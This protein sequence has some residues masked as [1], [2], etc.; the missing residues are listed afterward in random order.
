MWCFACKVSKYGIFVS[1]V[2]GHWLEENILIPSK[3]CNIS[4]RPFFQK[5]LFQF[6]SLSQ[7]P[8]PPVS[9]SRSC[10]NIIIPFLFANSRISFFTWLFMIL[11]VVAIPILN[12]D[13]FARSLAMGVLPKWALFPTGR[14]LTIRHECSRD[15]PSS[16]WKLTKLGL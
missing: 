12:L 13:L 5:T 9:T 2:C 11:I 14:R 16:T 15:S 6:S 10:K 1:K 3:C 4:I 8:K 7:N